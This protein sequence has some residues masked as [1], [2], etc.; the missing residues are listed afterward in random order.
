MKLLGLGNFNS[1]NYWSSTEY[2]GYSWEGGFAWNQNFSDGTHINGN[3]KDN[4]FNVR[5]VRS[6]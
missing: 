1:S 6:F 5:A 2:E 4:Q 3:D